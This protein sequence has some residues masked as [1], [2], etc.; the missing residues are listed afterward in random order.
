MKKLTVTAIALIAL[1]F[2]LSC[3]QEALNPGQAGSSDSSQVL[4]SQ[5]RKYFEAQH[6]PTNP[7]QP[8]DTL[9]MSRTTLH[10]TPLWNQARVSPFSFGTGV[11]VPIQ[12]QENLS[13]QVGAA[14]T[15]LSASNITWLLMYKDPIRHW[16]VEVITRIPDAVPLGAIPSP[17]QGT[18]QVED[19]QGNFL[20][21][22]RFQGDTIITYTQSS[23]AKKATGPAITPLEIA[24][25][26]PISG[27]TCTETDW[28]GCATIGDGPTQ[29]QYVYTSEDCPGTFS[30]A[31]DYPTT[32]TPT[33]PDY[34]T[35]G[36]GTSAT[37]APT[38][39]NIIP[40]A[41][42]TSNPIVACVYNHL[43][44]PLLTNG[45]K[46]IL[47]S[48]D[49]NT[50]YNV[51][52]TVSMGEDSA[53]GLC[54]YKGNN[55]FLVTIN[56]SDAND[57]NYS[58]IYLASIMIHE[59]FHAKLRQKALEVF[60]EATISQ[61][62]KPIDD[63]TLSELASYFEANSKADNIWEATEHDWMVNNIAQL[64]ASLE[65]FVQTFYPTT[66]AQV[67]SAIEPYEALMYMGL[68]TST[69]YQEQVVA[70]GLSASFQAYWGELN[71]GGKCSD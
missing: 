10:K 66:Y 38:A 31:N 40:D 68:Q 70:S 1:L 36:G 28:Y 56:G 34:S 54:S 50:M 53:D 59:A 69:L 60:G 27:T 64:A 44:S 14:Q 8:G 4:I 32:G 58:R 3:H 24:P 61:W 33:P 49:D 15:P 52:F 62:P 47:S 21:A 22:Y 2:A 39:V 25:T 23:I 9:P 17:F 46:S 57:S 67:G 30:A 71:E 5:A 41:T 55:T 20:K 6:Y 16:Q 19:W 7:S 63:M 13:I 48:F 51:D 43:M 35:V 18:V 42:I 29:C 45:L 65:Q 12:V 37:A 26:T 11:V